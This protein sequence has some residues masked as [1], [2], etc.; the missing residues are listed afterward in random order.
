MGFTEGGAPFG[1]RHR[2]DVRM[3]WADAKAV[4]LELLDSWG[5][6]PDRDAIGYIRRVGEGLSSRVFGTS[7]RRSSGREEWVVVKLPAPN[8]DSDRD[9]RL[10]REATV[11]R[12][13]AAQSLPFTIPR[14]V[15][16]I[17]VDAGL[18]T[19]QE[20]MDGD[21][22]DLRRGPAESPWDLVARVAAAIHAIDPTAFRA[23]IGG[24]A[25]R[26]DH[27]VAHASLLDELD[28]SEA[29]DTDGWVREHLP[30][31]IPSSL[32]H[33][34]LLDQNILHDWASER[35]AV[36]DWG[37]AMIGDPALD[38]AIVTRGVRKPFRD[39]HGRRRLL[40]AYNQLATTPL[41]L[42]AVHLHE[43]IMAADWYRLACRDYGRGSP[44]AEEHR[45]FWRSM[46][47]RASQGTE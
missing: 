32:V 43:L 29:R 30:A 16:E 1:L 8:A 15:G 44:H 34:D 42:S 12:L 5:E 4:L 39:P 35:I 41:L 23:L 40:D 36:V 47:K 38:L 2:S 31:A 10:M 24:H 26:R 33:G 19:V 11:L 21:P 37:E 46:L 13:L 7:I 20:M 9:E 27:A 22:F 3:N 25:T 28:E 14:P 45:R 17:E 18:A 6:R